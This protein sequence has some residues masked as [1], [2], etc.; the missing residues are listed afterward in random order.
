VRRIAV[1]LEDPQGFMDAFDTAR[2]SAG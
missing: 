2:P 1:S